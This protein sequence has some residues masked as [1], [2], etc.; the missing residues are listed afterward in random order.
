[1]SR[2]AQFPRWLLD[3]L[4]VCMLDINWFFEEKKFMEED[5]NIP[6]IDEESYGT[7]IGAVDSWLQA[8]L[9]QI[10]DKDYVVIPHQGVFPPSK[11]HLLQ[12]LSVGLTSR[13]GAEWE[14]QA[15][16]AWDRFIEWGFSGDDEGRRWLF[17]E[18]Q[19]D[20]VAKAVISAL[21]ATGQRD[22]LANA[23]RTELVPWQATYW[24]ALPN[25]VRHEVD[26]SSEDVFGSMSPLPF[27]YDDPHH[28][29]D[30]PRK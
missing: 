22:A 16:P 11:N 19:T 21:E 10:I 4:A 1:M 27:W 28:W 25:G 23:R 5:L 2:H 6:Y 24:K 14:S 12:D 26:V 15:K 9:L 20:Q 29:L 13:G 8:G 3:E 7:V 30:N 18:A 17:S